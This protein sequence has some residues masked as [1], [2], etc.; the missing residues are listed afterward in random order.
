MSERWD[1]RWKIRTEW[2]WRFG[3]RRRR[4]WRS[5]STTTASRWISRPI[6]SASSSTVRTFCQ[7]TRPNSSTSAMATLSRCSPVK[8]AAAPSRNFYVEIS[9]FPRGMI[10][11]EF[12]FIESLSLLL[13]TLISVVWVTFFAQQI[14]PNRSLCIAPFV[15]Y[16]N[17]INWLLSKIC[18][19][20]SVTRV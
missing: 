2:S 8:T 19:F 9:Q 17:V 10:R 20:S 16:L 1:F 3:T 5:C 18:I 4:R 15:C 13:R 6:W 14:I 12:M 11:L 7:R